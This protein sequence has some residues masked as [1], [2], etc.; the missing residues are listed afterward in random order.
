MMQEISQR[1]KLEPYHIYSFDDGSNAAEG[2]AAGKL[3]G[4]I[5]QSPEQMGERSV[6]LMMKWL[7]D[8]VVPL[9]SKGYITDIRV[10]EGDALTP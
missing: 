10:V 2:L 8:E 5:E 9:N 7:R 4:I 3:D 6:A 1:S